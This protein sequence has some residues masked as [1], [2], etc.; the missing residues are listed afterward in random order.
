MHKWQSEWVI[1]P[2]F[3]GCSC[4]KAGVTILFNSNCSFQ[5]SKTYAVP[6]GRFILC[7]LITNEKLI[8]LVN[9]YAP[10]KDIQIS[11]PLSLISY[12]ASN[13]KR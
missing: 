5:I 3:S 8:T 13:M 9:I 11:L 6:E 1:K 10:N 12:L 4:V 7:D 2:Y